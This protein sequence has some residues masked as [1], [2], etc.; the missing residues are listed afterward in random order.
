MN[1]NRIMK[2]IG[3]IFG[4]FMT[5]FYIGVGLYLALAKNLNVDDF[6]RKLVGF[7]FAFYGIYRGYRAFLN[8]RDAFFGSNKTDE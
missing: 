3:A 1:E 7:T 8:I 5:V 4:L 6:V 2:Q